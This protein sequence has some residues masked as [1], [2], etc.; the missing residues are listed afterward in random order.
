[1]RVKVKKAILWKAIRSKCMDCCAYQQTEVRE[2]PAESCPIWAYRM[3]QRGSPSIPGIC[4]PD[5]DSASSDTDPL[6]GEPS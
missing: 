5:A 6:L 1:M 3:G 4:T 2:C